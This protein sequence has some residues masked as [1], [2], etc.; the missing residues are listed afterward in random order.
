M[1]SVRGVLAACGIACAFSLAS[2]ARAQ[3]ANLLTDSGE[4]E[5]LALA[6]NNTLVAYGYFRE[7]ASTDPPS[8][9]ETLAAFRALYILRFGN[10]ALLPFDALLPVADLSV[11][12]RVP[13]APGGVATLHGSG[14]ADFTYEPSV[15]YVIPEGGAPET[16]TVLAATSFVTAPTGN[17]DV[18]RAVNI[19]DN[20]WRFQENVNVSQRLFRILAFS[21]IA[22]A[23]FYTANSELAARPG[24]VRLTQAPSFGFEGHTLVDLAP[25]VYVAASYYFTA[26]GQRTP[27]VGDAPV[28]GGQPGQTTQEIRFTLGIR[29]SKLSLLLLQYDQDVGTSGG[30]PIVRFFGVRFSHAVIF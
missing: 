28:T 7:F 16:R 26:V 13:G 27:W 4:Y 2:T 3:T 6:P 15:A 22:S 10:V 1:K 23:A 14:L 20:R 25:P 24:P 9:T 29:L 8:F 12:A 30:A 17:Y 19:G 5:R 21:F 11:S 18:S